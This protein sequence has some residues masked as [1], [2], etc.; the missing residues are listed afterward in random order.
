LQSGRIQLLLDPPSG[1]YRELASIREII[2]QKLRNRR[3]YFL[4]VNH[5]RSVLQSVALRRAIAY[6]I[7]REAILNT[8]FRN[9]EPTLHRPLNGPYPPD[10]WAC[11]PGLPAD[12]FNLEH[13][14]GLAPTIL[15]ERPTRELTL[16]FPDGDPEVAEACK[17]IQA[18]IMSIG[19]GIKLELKACP[20]R[21]LHRDV[22]FTHDYDLAY[23]SLD[24]ATDAY[25]LWPWL[26]PKATG[27]GGANFCGYTNDSLL[28]S[29]FHK[30]MAHRDPA[31]VQDLTRQIHSAFYEKMPFIPLWQL[32]T[33]LARH[34]SLIVSGQ[35]D[36]LH[37]FAEA[38]HWKIDKQ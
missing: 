19:A 16:K 24:Y 12:P 4:A 35:P 17:Q 1:R 14:K 15:D 38:E 2:V 27:E 13:A 33:L 25:W 22:E 8:V 11:Q 32:D 9:G 7:N 6:A 3:I 28:E 29:L 34:S 36:P 30:V 37:V 21:E 26:D 5:G 23:Y 20:M 10:S 18:A 31:L